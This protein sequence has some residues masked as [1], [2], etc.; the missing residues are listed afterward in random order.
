MVVLLSRLGWLGWPQGSRDAM[1]SRAGVGT[2]IRAGVGVGVGVVEVRRGEANAPP[3]PL[4]GRPRRV[5]HL[6]FT[7]HHQQGRGETGAKS[8][9]QR[10]ALGWPA[11]RSYGSL[12]SSLGHK[13]GYSRIHVACAWTR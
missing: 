1:S 9:E 7:V 8:H 13:Q 3:S 10:G 4:H 11:I 6:A 2:G 12:F 5:T